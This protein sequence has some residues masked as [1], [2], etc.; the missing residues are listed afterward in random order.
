MNG[1]KLAMAVSMA[2]LCFGGTAGAA[3]PAHS[4]TASAVRQVS[5]TPQAAP[6]V[7]EKDASVVEGGMTPDDTAA[8]A[9]ADE[10]AA[11]RAAAAPLHIGAG[12]TILGPAEASQDQMVRYIRMRNPQPQ[13]NCTVEELV[14][15]YYQEA[16]EEGVRPDV[17]LCQAI[18]ETD[19][20]GYGGDVL[21]RQ[22]NY[23]GLGAT[24]GGVHGFSF[25]TPQRGVRAHIQHLLAYASTR[26]PKEGLLDPRYEVLRTKYP[27]F[28]G[29]IPYWTG[30][31]GKWAV[32]GKHY[33]EDI[34]D[35][36]QEAKNM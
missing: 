16:G 17:A 20:F 2:A 1:L 24:G 12:T 29:Q 28:Y 26:L 13:L 32:P 18:K 9:K 8:A 33:G 11:A 6:A 19:C 15:A 36:W 7:S 21:P 22:N 3:V 27:Q 35:I 31:D 34:L 25:M 14:A 23:C 5:G 10:A 4:G 30:L